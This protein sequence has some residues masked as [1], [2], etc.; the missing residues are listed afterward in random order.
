[1]EDRRWNLS[2]S[3]MSIQLFMLAFHT[4]LSIRSKHKNKL[5]SLVLKGLRFSLTPILPYINF[6]KSLNRDAVKCILKTGKEF[7]HCPHHKT[8]S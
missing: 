3:L 4:I 2:I 8:S 6:L 7:S 1:M 5:I